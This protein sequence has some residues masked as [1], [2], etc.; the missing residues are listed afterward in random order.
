MAIKQ[1]HYFDPKNIEEACSLLYEHRGEAR[2]LAGGQSLLPMMKLNLVEPKYLIDLKRVPGLSFI[3]DSKDNETGRGL[4]SVGAL[5]THSEIANSELLIRE[6]PLLSETASGIG[7]PQVRNRGTIGGSLSHCDPAA[8]LVATMLALEANI[9]LASHG[10]KQRKVTASSFFKGTFTTDLRE[11][12]ILTQVDVEPHSNAV[13][14]FKKMI[15]GHGDF[16]LVVVSTSLRFDKGICNQAAI[17][18]AGVGEVAFRVNDAENT[19]LGKSQITEEDVSLAAKI[20]AEASKPESDLE[21]SAEYK[22]KMVEVFVRRAL[23]DALSKRSEPN[24]S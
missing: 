4:I 23:T 8:D 21:V 7:H 3:R 17:A 13:Y 5:T 24:A 11:G 18:L 14:S 22:R 12:E 1:F 16:P 2:I 20:S 19:L 15:L 10:G 6:V 9:I